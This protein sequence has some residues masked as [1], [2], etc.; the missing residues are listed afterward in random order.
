MRHKDF[1]I[2]G[3]QIAYAKALDGNC[4]SKQRLALKL[5]LHP[6]RLSPSRK[7]TAMPS[8]AFYKMIDSSLIEK[9]KDGKYS[10]K[11]KVLPT[12]DLITKTIQI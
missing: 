8:R 6:I 1:A 7:D 2:I 4:L 12:I 5:G 3:Y 11:C 9:D 10:L